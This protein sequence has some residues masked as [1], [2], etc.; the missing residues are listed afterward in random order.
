VY[1]IGSNLSWRRWAPPLVYELRLSCRILAPLMER[2]CLEAALDEK[3]QLKAARR[4]L[5]HDMRKMKD[6]DRAATNK[7]VLRGPLLNTVLMIY[8]LADCTAAPASMYL[9]IAARKRQWPEK[10]EEEVR[11]LVEQCFVDAQIE[12]LTA[13]LDADTTADKV[14]LK[15]AVEFVEQWRL[16]VVV[17]GFNYKQGV[18]VSTDAV[19]KRYETNVAE[20]PEDVR[21][22]LRGTSDQP[23]A[24][25]WTKR[26]RA[27]WGGKYGKIKVVEEVPPVET[28]RS[29]AIPKVHTASAEFRVDIWTRIPGRY[30]DPENGPTISFLFMDPDSGSEYRPGIRVRISTRIPALLHDKFQIPVTN[31]RRHVVPHSAPH[32]GAIVCHVMFRHSPFGSGGGI[33]A[34]NSLLENLP[35]GSTWTRLR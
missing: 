4:E 23:A 9:M 15:K 24:R 26:W 33:A 25:M 27:R 30:L 6:Q 11:R 22:P 21:P 20:L 34:A 8:S 2:T 3:A 35:C 14:G 31:R 7:W 12:E 18:A 17:S 16:R 29:K 5:K 28:M 19:L 32:A 13:L 1:D 10:E